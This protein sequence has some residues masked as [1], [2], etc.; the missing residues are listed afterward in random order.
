[1]Y[2]FNMVTLDGFF[3]GPKKW[4]IDWHNVDA[5]FNEF[6]I[7]QLNATDV[8]LFGRGTYEGMA[9]YWPTPRAVEN[10]PVVAGK[11]NSIPKLVFSR[12]LRK[13]EWSNTRIIS[14]DISGEIARLK[15]APGKDVAIFGSANLASSLNQMGAIDEYR[16]I[17]NPVILGAGNPL[18]KNLNDKRRLR[19]LKSRAFES[20]N[21]LL[22]YAPNGEEKKI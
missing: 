17:V 10:D 15:Q 14:D 18:F 11:M 8:I 21:V 9:S 7:D 19:L 5:E 20:G 22:V 16:L 3:E 2:L 12:T 6:A 13:A 1:M 4:E